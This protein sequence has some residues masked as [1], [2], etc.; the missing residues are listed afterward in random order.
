M[1]AVNLLLGPVVFFFPTGR[2]VGA[3]RN[4]ESAIFL[5]IFRF[6]GA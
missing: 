3:A 1:E 5:R 6:S 4:R 2:G